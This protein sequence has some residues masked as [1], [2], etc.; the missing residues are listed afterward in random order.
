LNKIFPLLASLLVPTSFLV[1]AC[2]GGGSNEG[3]VV[4]KYPPAPDGASGVLHVSTG[5]PSSDADGSAEHP[6]PTITAALQKS[7]KGDTL[8]VAPGTYEENV[9]IDHDITIVGPTTPGNAGDAA[10]IILQAPAPD[11]VVV[12]AGATATLTGF[13]V[14]GAQGIG[15]LAKGGTANVSASKIEG[16]T[17]DARKNG[18]GATS[19][20]NGAIIL[21]DVGISGCA[22]I[23]VYVTGATATIDKCDISHNKGSG[24]RLDQASADVTI[25]G[26]TLTGNGDFAVGV[27][28]SGA[29]ILQNHIADTVAADLKMGDGI[30]ANGI[31][32]KNGMYLG[33][34]HVNAHDNVITNSARVG[35]LMSAGASGIIL[36]KNTVSG[37]AA[38]AAFGAGIWLQAGAG[39]AMGNTLDGNILTGNKFAGIGLSG[40]TH[41]II[42]QNNQVSGTT[43]GS[44]IVDLSEVQ[45]GDGISLFKGASALLKGNKSTQNGRFGMILDGEAGGSATTIE[46]NT[47]TDNDQYGIILQNQPATM[48]TIGANTVMGNKVG[49]TLTVGASMTA[50]G[51]HSAD[52]ATK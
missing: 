25:S 45:I 17:V 13:H 24:I 47:L 46:G 36:Q 48:P 40:D 33:D 51:V 20:A 30:V 22:L 49:D 28:S 41:G 14:K 1:S 9:T 23:G 50:F 34:S 11:A 12:N 10:G 37:S 2:G 38:S 6:Y 44:T 5:C 27:F 42:L 52:F 7:A 32:D 15:V 35:V 3:C 29:I 26:N 31:S 19:S 8:L 4:D 39:G 21:Q 43:L 16:T 18:Y